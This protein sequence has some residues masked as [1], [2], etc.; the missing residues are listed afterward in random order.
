MGLKSG[1]GGLP[2]VGG[3]STLFSALAVTGIADK[4]APTGWSQ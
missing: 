1:I 4:H 2:K 3:K